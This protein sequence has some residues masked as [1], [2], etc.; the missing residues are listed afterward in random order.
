M[1]GKRKLPDAKLFVSWNIRRTCS[2]QS[3]PQ[4]IGVCFLH[5]RESH[6]D[7]QAVVARRE[8]RKLVDEMCRD[9]WV[10]E[11]RHHSK[12]GNWRR[13]FFISISI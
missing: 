2:L 13:V 4:V 1:N 11:I 5:C 9:G 8:V 3:F 7:R 6:P 12:I 10:V